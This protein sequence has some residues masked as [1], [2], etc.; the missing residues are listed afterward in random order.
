MNFRFTIICF[1]CLLLTANCLFVFSSC[2]EKQPTPVPADVLPKEKMAQVFTDIHMAEA[3]ANAPMI[4]DIPAKDLDSISKSNISFQKIFDKN[5]ITKE[6][7][8]K[9][10]QFY[11][12]HPELLDKVYEEVLN[13]LSKMQG[14]ASK[15]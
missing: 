1:Y 2:G 12:D 13:E 15:P 4:T 8:D 9:S 11:I 7:Y 6:Q 3:G 10:L 14:E 5:Q